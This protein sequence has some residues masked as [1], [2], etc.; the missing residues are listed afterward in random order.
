MPSPGFYTIV[1]CRGKCKKKK[2]KNERC[3]WRKDTYNSSIYIN[4]AS[5]LKW[6]TEPLSGTG[7]DQLMISWEIWINSPSLWPW[8]TSF[9]EWR[10]MLFRLTTSLLPQEELIKLIP[11]LKVTGSRAPSGR[12]QPS[13]GSQHPEQGRHSLNSITWFVPVTPS[14][15]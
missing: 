12:T 7:W 1:S 15:C 8:N 9:V 6:K 14:V 4:G 2:K 5:E 10:V 11:P 3:I 13:W